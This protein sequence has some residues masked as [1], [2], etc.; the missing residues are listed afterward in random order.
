MSAAAA[1]ATAA[2]AVTAVDVLAPR[3]VDRG[4]ALAGLRIES[5]SAGDDHSS[6]VTYPEGT[7]SDC[8]AISKDRDNDDN[9]QFGARSAGSST[10]ASLVSAV[11]GDAAEVQHGGRGGGGGG[12]D[13]AVDGSRGSPGEVGSSRVFTW[14]LNKA[15][16]C[17]HGRVSE[18]VWL[19][20]EAELLSG[21]RA[22][23]C[24]AG[25]T[26]VVL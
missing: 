22:V 2:A 20:Q 16:Q 3:V 23:G 9:G 11:S 10:S 8:I 26:L 14:G 5:V 17:V 15:G 12:I 7:A 19:P 18:I 24:G 1:T 25:H 21:A 6:A 13:G 4:T